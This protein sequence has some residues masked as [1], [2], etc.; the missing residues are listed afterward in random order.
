MLVCKLHTSG[1]PTNFILDV[2]EDVE[3]A[4]QRLVCIAD[5]PRPTHTEIVIQL[6]AANWDPARARYHQIVLIGLV[7]SYAFNA[8]L[9]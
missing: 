9:A 3:M 5:H 4:I 1:F 6:Q 7:A 8:A 2:G